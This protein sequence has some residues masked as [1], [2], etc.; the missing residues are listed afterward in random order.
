ML[1]PLS[2]LYSRLLQFAS[3]LCF[4]QVVSEPT[5]CSSGTS[6]LIDLVFMSVPKYLIS[7]TTIPPLANSD[8]LAFM[9]PLI[10]VVLEQIQRGNIATYG[11]IPLQSSAGPVIYL[12]KLTGICCLPLETSMSV[13]PTGVPDF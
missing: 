11:G 1:N 9:F 4:T 5:H 10:Q 6:S 2:H 12:M 7:C 13:W 3:S 8:H